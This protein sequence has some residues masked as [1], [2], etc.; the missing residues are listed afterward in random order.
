M[1][2]ISIRREHALGVRKAKIIMDKMAERLAE[3]YD[4]ETQ[5]EGDMLRF[6][7]GGIAGNMRVEDNLLEID[8][9]VGMMLRPFRGQIEEHL[10]TALDKM[11]YIKR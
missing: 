8:M 6:R 7:R 3:E 5:W 1:P 9:D 4:L 11:L 2:D 10:H